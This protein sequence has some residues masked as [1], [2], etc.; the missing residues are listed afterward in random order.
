MIYCIRITSQREFEALV[1]LGEAMEYD[2]EDS[3]WDEYPF[4]KFNTEERNMW[5]YSYVHNEK[6]ISNATLL[7]V[8][9][10]L[11]GLKFEL[12]GYTVNFENEGIRVGCKYLVNEAVNRLIFDIAKLQTGSGAGELRIA[13]TPAELEAISLVA[14][15]K[16]YVF[17]RSLDEHTTWQAHVQT[18]G[19]G[20]V[21]E[22]LHLYAKN[23]SISSSP[24]RWGGEETPNL[25]NIMKFL[26]QEQSVTYMGEPVKITDSGITIQGYCI[27]IEDYNNFVEEWKRLGRFREI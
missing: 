27:N 25:E 17:H 8:Y 6:D 21:P 4:M 10:H 3:E 16:G 2:C 19:L 1:K 14:V 15:A 9:E 13:G 12:A 11:C 23:K 7:E 24:G 22:V 26:D 18:Y 20:K 5:T